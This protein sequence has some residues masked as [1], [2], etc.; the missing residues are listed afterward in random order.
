MADVL[1]LN[2]DF[3]PLSLMPLS[4]V[5]WQTAI[6]LM[7]LGKVSVIKYHDNW[8][9][10]SPSTE[11]QVPSIVITTQYVRCRKG[12]V[13]NRYSVYLR[14]NFTCQYCG[15]HPNS[16]AELTFDHV[17]PKSLGGTTDWCNVTTACRKCNSEKG[18][19]ASIVPKQKP[20]EPSFYELLDKRKKIILMKDPHWLDFFQS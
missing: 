15:A 18:N 10:R 6:R 17:L 20:Y 5:S 12:V 7:I 14:D 9:V 2:T 16:M 8:V 4:L 13:F 1:V 19:D 3:T 11:F